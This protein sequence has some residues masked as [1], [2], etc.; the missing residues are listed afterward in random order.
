MLCICTDK[1]GLC[2]HKQ[3]H[4][5]AYNLL[6]TEKNPYKNFSK[7]LQRCK[8]HCEIC[9]FYALFLLIA[10]SHTVNKVERYFPN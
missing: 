4:H 1:V 2:E 5:C 10:L 3:L 9:A 8:K 6:Q 7:K